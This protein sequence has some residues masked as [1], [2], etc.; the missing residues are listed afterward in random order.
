MSYTL[1][2]F[3]N[4]HALPKLK[5]LISESDKQG[6]NDSVESPSIFEKFLEI[7][8]GLA[9]QRRAEDFY[10]W[11]I[12]ACVN[13]TTEQMSTHKAIEIVFRYLREDAKLQYIKYKEDG[14]QVSADYRQEEETEN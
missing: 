9:N 8:R 11:L 6:L 4:D 10:G 5:E 3:F 1:E 7:I 13:P 14:A 2:D 12:D